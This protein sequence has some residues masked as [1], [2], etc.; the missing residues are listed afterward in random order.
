M[1]TDVHDPAVNPLGIE[2]LGEIGI[3]G[4]NAAI[5]SAVFHATDR[6]IRHLPIR[7]EDVLWTLS[8]CDECCGRG[9]GAGARGV[10]LSSAL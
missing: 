8:A 2:G 1:T 7:I 3:V 9:L 10:N 4:M 6:Q 5:A